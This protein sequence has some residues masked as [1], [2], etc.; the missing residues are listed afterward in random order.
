ME[1][2]LEVELELAVPREEVFA[3]FSRAANLERITPPELRFRILTPE[4][5]AMREGTIIDYRLRL[6][7]VPFGWRT[8]ISWWEPPVR[9]VDEQL[10][11]PY[12]QWIHEHTFEER[13]AGTL[14]RDRV[15]YRLPLWPAGEVALPVV[16]RQLDRIFAYRQRAVREA[17]TSVGSERSRE[18]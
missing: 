16:R 15:R 17:L 9:F 5:I 6:Y 10:G 12:A 8:R 18:R 14:I 13:A 1:H 4:P 2:V 7:G 3:F 11:G